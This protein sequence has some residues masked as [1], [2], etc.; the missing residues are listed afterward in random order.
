MA[1]LPHDEYLD[2][3]DP[4]VYSKIIDFHELTNYIIHESTKKITRLH[5]H[6]ADTISRLT[7]N[8]LEVTPCGK[9]IAVKL[10]CLAD[11]HPLMRAESLNT[12]APK[13]VCFK[14]LIQVLAPLV[15]RNGN[16]SKRGFPSGGALYPVETFICRLNDNVSG[17][18][19][20]EDVLHLLPQEKA[21]EPIATLHGRSHLRSAIIPDHS[22]IGKPSTAIVL[23]A[24]LPK[25]V[26]KYRY[27]GYRLGL[28]EAGSMYQLIELSAKHYN[29][30]TRVW[31]G[32]CDHM[33]TT[34]FG[35]NPTLYLPLCTV[36]IGH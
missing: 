8:Q 7:G 12:F 19:C 20:D 23:A 9:R 33:I 26:F 35:L 31:A 17:W 25:T 3:I 22:G 5:Y 2:Y 24:Y 10:E 34:S 27:R 4:E 14:N 16:A 1:N 32:F 13:G 30:R 11:E 18:P 36:L 28:M 29:L 15:V 6:S 21:F